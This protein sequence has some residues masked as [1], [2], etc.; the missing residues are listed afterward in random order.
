M[1]MLPFCIQA[2]L[3]CQ[4]TNNTGLSDTVADMTLCMA[5]R[6]QSFEDIH[7]LIKELNYLTFHRKE[8]SWLSALSLAKGG[9][10]SEPGSSAPAT[11]GTSRP[12]ASQT[13]DSS[14]KGKARQSTLDR[15]ISGSKAQ[16]SK[17]SGPVWGPFDDSERYGG[18]VPQRQ[19]FRDSFM[20]SRASLHQR[21][22]FNRFMASLIGETACGDHFHKPSKL[23]HVGKGRFSAGYYSIRTRCARSLGKGIQHFWAD[24]PPVCAP[25]LHNIWAD[26][27][28][29][30]DDLFHWLDRINRTIPAGHPL[31]RLF[32]AA[33][34]KAVFSEVNVA[35]LKLLRAALEAEDRYSKEQIEAFLN[36]GKVRRYIP[37]PVIL[38]ERLIKVME[39]FSNLQDPRNQVPVISAAT[40]HTFLVNL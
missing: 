23:V 12:L 21:E 27:Q 18:Y 1:E 35:D 9:P 36:T 14:A 17:E 8:L 3:P 2:Q 40:W 15:M 16:N 29:V 38:A 24:D 39:E 22:Y 5:A 19:Y 20:G 26:L 11:Q 33:M 31:K 37:S 32:A 34:A 6:R 10:S 7:T 13:I 4:L 28:T 25:F 30:K